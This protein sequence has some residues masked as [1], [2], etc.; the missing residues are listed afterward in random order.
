MM[1]RLLSAV[2]LIA[3]LVAGAQVVSTTPPADQPP[4]PQAVPPPPPATPPAPQSSAP[5][6]QLPQDDTYDEGEALPPAD[7]YASPPTAV[8]PAAPSGQWVWTDQYGWIW[9]PYGTAYTYLPVGAYPDMYVYFPAYGWRWCVAPWVWGIGPRP[10]FGV[11]GWARFGWYGRG[12]GRWYGFHGGPVWAGRGWGHPGWYGHPGYPGTAVRPVPRLGFAAARPG[13]FARSGVV[14]RPAPVARGG[15]SAPHG[16][17]FSAP[18]G[19]TFSAPHGGSFSAP[20]G[21]GFSGG[22]AVAHGGFGRR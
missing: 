16:G 19:G 2:L 15:F 3:P 13:G 6:E 8:A 12:Y 14:A 18:H 22:H 4:A 20:R 17:T 10:F 9:M 1:K 7:Q 21:G 11:Y 5:V